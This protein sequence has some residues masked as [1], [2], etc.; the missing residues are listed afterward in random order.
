MHQGEPG[1]ILTPA[2][3][4][5]IL[6]CCVLASSACS[7]GPRS[8]LLIT[9]DTLRADHLS[10]YGYPLPTAAAVDRLA[11][12]G[13]LFRF[14]F[15]ASSS[16]APSHVSMFTGR[17]P[18]FHSTGN[19]NGQI[20]L[21]HSAT[22]LAEVLS[23]RGYATAAI[24][25][26]P[27]LA[28]AHLGLDQGF[29]SY[30]DEMDGKELN[31]EIRHQV[32]DRAVTK[33]ID[34]LQAMGPDPYFLWLHLQDPHGPYNPPADWQCPPELLGPD[35]DRMLAAGS[36]HSGHQAI[37]RYQ[38]Y[39]E[40]RRLDEYRRRYDCE[41]AYFDR[42]L[43]RLLSRLEQD[44]RNTLVILTSDHG[45]AFGEDDFYFA[46]G[47][48]VGLDLVRV[49]MIMAGPGLPRGRQ[50]E[51]P[52]SNVSLFATVLDLL[53]LE[54]PRGPAEPSL[55]PLIDQPSSSQRPVFVECLNQV[56]VISGNT[57]LRRDRHPPEAELWAGRNPNS[58]G[59]WKPLGRQVLK[60]D[61]AAGEAGEAIAELEARLEDFE[62]RAAEIAPHLKTLGEQAPLS[63]EDTE[64]LRSLGYLN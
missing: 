34:R 35:D 1:D 41:I 37:P 15:A 59:F 12:R 3:R 52:V 29:D 2:L 58:G 11:A 21:H 64:A 19:Y 53:Q 62:R 20:R 8:V 10:T 16:T 42:Q 30:D 22:T 46:H 26:N 55:A 39:G 60:L 57:F 6:A 31:R 32:A 38:L 17:Y 7:E 50:V 27:V 24:V 61:P 43:D 5:L 28:A 4:P 56:G 51:T 14:A 18:S 49:P 45:E 47:H 63:P 13:V 36:D 33:A 44:H 40:E 48:S 54:A 23:A 9:V 25:S